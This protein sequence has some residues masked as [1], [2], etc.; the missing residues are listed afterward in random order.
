MN[1]PERGMALVMVLVF[2]GA[3]MLLGTVMLTY[4][5]NENTIADYQARETTLYYL[6]EAGLEAGIAALGQDFDH[7]GQLTGTLTEGHFTVTF[8]TI[9]PTRRLVTA[10][11]TES[12]Q[13]FEKTLTVEVIRDPPESETLQVVW[14]DLHSEE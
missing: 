3:L 5:F 10:K 2:I 6:A 12:N 4:S 7:Q 11:A 9:D 1:Q 8:N 14:L 13:G